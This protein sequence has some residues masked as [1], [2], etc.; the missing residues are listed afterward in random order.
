MR[1]GQPSGTFGVCYVNAP[2]LKRLR[3]ARVPSHE[4]VFSGK[5]RL[6]DHLP[7]VC[8]FD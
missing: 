1:P 2:M 8:E 5:P 7:I 4:E 6:S 3:R